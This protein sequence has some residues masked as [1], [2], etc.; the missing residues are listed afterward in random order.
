MV[1]FLVDGPSKTTTARLDILAFARA[2]MRQSS[3]DAF[4]SLVNPKVAG[5]WL[6][7]SDNL[8]VGS[9]HQKEIFEPYFVLPKSEHAVNTIRGEYHSRNFG[10]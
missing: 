8:V 1:L 10:L 7:N 2:A 9:L 6:P 4:L 5:A 3:V